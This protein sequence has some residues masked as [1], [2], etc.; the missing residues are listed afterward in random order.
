MFKSIT[1]IPAT[2]W[3]HTSGRTASIYGACPWTH[4]ADRSD[5]KRETVG[6]TH[7]CVDHRGSVTIGFG[8]PPV[9]TEIEAQAVADRLMSR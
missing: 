4:D 9:A 8:R 1:V 5:W 3:V 7:E 2:R 6:F